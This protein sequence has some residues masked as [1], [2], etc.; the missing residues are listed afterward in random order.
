MTQTEATTPPEKPETEATETAAAE[1]PS[2][3]PAEDAAAAEKKDGDKEK[4]VIKLQYHYTTNLP[5]LLDQLNISIASTTYQARRV[6]TFASD[7]K[8]L[9]GLARVFERVTGLAFKG[10][11]MALCAKNQIW[12]LHGQTELRDPKG[13]KLPYDI[14]YVPRFSWV[15]GDIAAHDCAWVGDELLVVNTRFSCISAMHSDWSFVPRW[16]P[17]FISAIVAEDRCHLNGMAVDDKGPR[18]CTALGETDAQGAWRE[19]KRTGGI[20]IDVQRNEIISRG[21]CMPHSP[22]L[23]AGQLFALNSGHGEL[24]VV[25]QQTGEYRTVAKFPGYTRGLAFAGRFAFVGLCKIREKNVFDNMPVA[26]NDAELR[27]GIWVYDMQAGQHVGQIEFLSGIEE[28]YDIVLLHGIRQ[29]HVIGFQENTID[30]VFIVP[31][32]TI[33]S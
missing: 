18:Y 24:V 12:L 8:V 6:M 23:H 14:C 33:K 20:I 29:P 15:T 7:G 2:S 1:A 13:D 10:R 25:N 31:S 16:K 5:A 26:E 28:M 11:Q 21:L 32:N 9:N 30:G 4:E 19:N 27:S 22:R 17:K 3:T